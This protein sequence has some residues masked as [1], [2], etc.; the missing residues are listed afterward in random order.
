[1]SVEPQSGPRVTVLTQSAQ[2]GASS[3]APR[4]TEC[5]AV[6]IGHRPGHET[7]RALLERIAGGERG[8]Q[9]RSQVASW[10]RGA[11]DEQVEEAFQEACARAERS[12]TGQS[13]GEVYVWLRTTT[14][15]ELGTM[16]QRA[17][18]E[19]LVDVSNAAFEPVERSAGAP[20]DDLIEREDEAEIERLTRAVLEQLSERQ[21]AIVALHSHGVRRRQIAEHLHLTPRIVKRSLE[22]I[23]A[24]GRTELV[25]LADLYLLNSTCRSAP[26]DLGG[27]RAAAPPPAEMPH[28]ASTCQ[29]NLAGQPRHVAEGPEAGRRQAEGGRA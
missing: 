12:C 9:L 16:R 18:R 8:A 23:M 22:Q 1:M 25:R 21:R 19:V 3:L 4:S 2:V 17:Q 15:H 10:N 24:A 27:Q 7:T 28:P 20:I 6:T 11:A 29:I 14:H 13:E 26:V 5:V